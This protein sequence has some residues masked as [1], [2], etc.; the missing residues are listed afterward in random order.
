MA[1]S[2]Y[3]R[4][5]EGPIQTESIR[6]ASLMDRNVLTSTPKSAAAS[7]ELTSALPV[8]VAAMS[9]SVT[10]AKTSSACCAFTS[11]HWIERTV[12]QAQTLD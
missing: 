11:R 5:P 10:G 6:P 2:E 3:R 12:A 1:C 9:A 8:K 4:D 7:L